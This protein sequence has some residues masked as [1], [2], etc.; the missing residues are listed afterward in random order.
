MVEL[1]KLPTT[2]SKWIVGASCAFVVPCLLVAW[3]I[4]LA[5]PPIGLLTGDGVKV[6]LWIA[7]AIGAA[8]LWYLPIQPAVKAAAT[9]CYIPAMAFCLYVGAINFENLIH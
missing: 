5:R 3:S 7:T 1:Q 9:I 6:T 8:G 4:I 2:K